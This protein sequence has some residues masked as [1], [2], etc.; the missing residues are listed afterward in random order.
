MKKLPLSFY[1]RKV[2]AKIQLRKPIIPLSTLP[3]SL[4]TNK[5]TN[6]HSEILAQLKLR[7]NKNLMF[8]HNGKKI[9]ACFATTVCYFFHLEFHIQRSKDGDG[10]WI[11]TIIAPFQLHSGCL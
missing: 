5:Q 2:C 6:K 7:T 8:F 10:W 11:E 9:N 4:R 3:Q 1:L